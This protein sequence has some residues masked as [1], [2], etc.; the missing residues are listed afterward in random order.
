MAYRAEIE[1][2]VRG[3]RSLEQLRSEINKSAAAAESLN[4]VVGERGGLV[5]NVQNYVN[6]LSRAA[7]T[8]QLVT[9]GTRAETKAIQEKATALIQLNA[10]QERQRKLLEAE[11]KAQ[12]EQ[13]RLRRLTAAGIFETT[14]F[15]QPI[16]P[17]PSP[18]RGQ[19]SPV[20]ERIE[21]LIAQR[22]DETVLQQALLKLEQRKAEELN[23]QLQIRGQ[24]N[25]KVAQEVNLVRAGIRPGTQYSQPIGPSVAPTVGGTARGRTGDII[26]NALIGGGFPL[27]FGQG[28]GAAA[29][30]AL[31]GIAG[32]ALGG[33]FG[34]ALSIVGT[35]IGQA[36]EEADKFN[37]ALAVLNTTTVNTGNAAK[38]TAQDI[39]NLAQNLSITKEEA[40]KLLDVFTGFNNA[41]V[42]KSL[43]FIYGADPSTFQGLAAVK[44]QA[45]LAEVILGTYQKIGIERATQLINQLKLGD[46]ASVE[47]AFQK[48]L[49][50][51]KVKQTEE[52]LRQITIQDRIIAGLA[53]IGSLDGGG[54]I[55]DPAI[56]G[57]ERVRQFRA[58]NRSQDLLKNALN[59]LKQL[60]TATRTAESLRPDRTARRAA[61]AAARAAEREAERVQRLNALLKQLREEISI[62]TR[63]LQIEENVIRARAD[64]DDQALAE[65][66][67]DKRL[68]EIGVKRAKIQK[69]FDA[70]RIQ[71]AEYTLRLQ[72]I[73]LDR[74]EDQIKSEAELNRIYRERFGLTDAITRAGREARERAFGNAPGAAG[75]AGQFRTD[76]SL[77]PGLTNGVIG[78]QFAQLRTELEELVK[79]ENQVIQAAKSIGDAFGTS[80]KGVI[81]G[82][83]TAQE[84]LA[85]FF[86]SVADHFADMA[87]QMISKWLQMQILGLA[88]SLLPGG[89]TVFPQGVGNF[90]GAFGG[91]GPLFQLGAFGGAR[92]AGG[93]VASGSTYMVGERGPELFVPRSSGTIVP[94]HM[95]GGG[96]VNVVVNVDASGSTVQGDSPN[97][98]QMGRVIGAAVQAEIVKMQRPGGLLAGTR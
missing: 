2:G 50:D 8:L 42:T 59:A 5:Q 61:D 49:L 75:G 39:D 88:Q 91:G 26:S 65:L 21:R 71:K 41:E 33:T 1:I 70:G 64:Q 48:A 60:R 82:T 62:R 9:A 98:N 11:V 44:D 52:G 92:A 46:S 55:T 63:S 36:A 32:G 94:N 85:N 34:F 43:A 54:G 72:L 10:I 86:Q 29:G 77:M 3:V 93:P 73:G 89:S 51:A 15:T 83:M 20:G 35:A 79:V 58:R 69:D 45:D 30:G 6:N 28:P 66:E 47:L 14:R 68:L 90:S 40:L 80:L 19:T 37:K 38:L 16:G 27:L 96:S 87:A 18:L 57:E 74:L 56:F 78:E 24:L 22:K 23:R 81:T 95:L 7:T 53:T 12:Q 17:Q 67:S 25:A 84:A 97:A 76:I 4:R 13:A 31:G